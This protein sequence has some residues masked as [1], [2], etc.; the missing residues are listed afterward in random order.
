MQV[1][2]IDKT[3]VHIAVDDTLI[4]YIRYICHT[5]VPYVYIDV[6][7]VI[8]L[9]RDLFNSKLVVCLHEKI[10]KASKYEQNTQYLLIRSGKL[11]PQYGESRTNKRYIK[12]KIEITCKNLNTICTKVV[13]NIENL[14]PLNGQAMRGANTAHGSL[15]G[16]LFFFA[17]R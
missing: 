16:F 6:L 2:Q 4:N 7:S 5:L 10:A 13:V 8:T 17:H 1:D 3:N 14:E 9:I 15:I 11:Q 12:C